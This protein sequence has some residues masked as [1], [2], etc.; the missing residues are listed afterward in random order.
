M[1]VLSIFRSFRHFSLVKR[2]DEAAQTYSDRAEIRD[3]VDFD[4]RVELRAALE[5]R[6]HLVC[7][8]AYFAAR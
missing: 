2:A 7:Q 4:L 6:T 5:N 8:L 3:L 1:Y